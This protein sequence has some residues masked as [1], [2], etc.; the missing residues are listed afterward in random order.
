MIDNATAVKYYID[1]HQ[2]LQD[3]SNVIFFF[4]GV[5]LGALILT[6]I[7]D[8]YMK[9]LRISGRKLSK[10]GVYSFTEHTTE[11]LKE[12]LDEKT[13]ERKLR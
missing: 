6:F 5:I 7:V 9:Q 10:Y 8:Y 3:T 12:Y 4:L 11:T 13:K 2:S 1:A